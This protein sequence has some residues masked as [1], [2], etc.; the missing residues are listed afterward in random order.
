MFLF[1]RI[2]PFFCCLLTGLSALP[3]QDLHFSQP[4][5]QPPA[6]NPALTG[7]MVGPWR[8]M[9]AYRDQWSSVP[10]AYRTVSAGADAKLWK[11]ARA[12]AA[13]GLFLSH[14]QAGD[15]GLRW[16]QVGI[17]GS[18]AQA[19][20]ESQALSVGAGLGAIQRSFDFSSLRVKN[21][22]DGTQYVPGLPTKELLADATGANLTLSA[23]LNWHFQ[24]Q[25]TRTR[26][27]LGAA[28]AHLNQPALSFDE[29]DPY[30]LPTRWVANGF[31]AW[32]IG[33]ATDL[34][35]YGLWQR[36]E[37]AGETLAGAGARRILTSGVANHTAL[38]LTLGIRPGDALIPA[39][40]VER[41]DWTVGFS[42][43]ANISGFDV[44]TH[45]RGGFEL[46][47]VYSPLPVPP[48]KTAKACPIF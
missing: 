23:G 11:K 20:G 44:A 43:D 25:G 8:A 13:G 42:Y 21:Q 46:A 40:Q 5:M 1:H 34:V 41:N 30:Q 35:F 27:D 45:Q 6:I 12:M 15:L 47:V 18:Y 22:W 9:A 48:V 14:D 3:A 37:S 39:I 24:P 38:Q 29:N 2:L 16:T 28:G 31:G 7:V 4:Y 32:Q 10:V 26:I 19:L 36:M 33:D 17:T